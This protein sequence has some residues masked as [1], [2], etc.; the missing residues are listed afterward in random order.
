MLCY[1]SQDL[2]R[3]IVLDGKKRIIKLLIPSTILL[4][5]QNHKGQTKDVNGQKI[6]IGWSP[7]GIKTIK[8]ILLN[9]YKRYKEKYSK[10]WKVEILWKFLLGLESYLFRYLKHVI[11]LKE[12]LPWIKLQNAQYSTQKISPKNNKFI[13]NL[14]S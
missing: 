6:K 3:K 14:S 7:Q 9:R 10:K 8:Y 2:C 11:H 1:F 5:C 12:V 13:I 4:F